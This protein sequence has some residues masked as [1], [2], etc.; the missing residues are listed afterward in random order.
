MSLAH[1]LITPRA[2]ECRL[3][4]LLQYITGQ[5]HGNITPF[6]GFFNNNRKNDFGIFIRREYG[7]K[8]MV[9]RGS[10]GLRR[11]SFC[12]RRYRKLLQKL[13]GAVLYRSTHALAYGLDML[14]RNNVAPYCF[15]LEFLK[16]REIRIHKAI[17]KTRAPKRAAVCDGRSGSRKLQRRYPKIALAYGDVIR[18]AY[19][20]L[21][22]GA[23]FFIRWRRHQAVPFSGNIN[24]KSFSKSELPHVRAYF[25]HSKPLYAA[26]STAYGI[27]INITGKRD[28]AQYVQRAQRGIP[29]ERVYFPANVY[30]GNSY[31]AAV[32]YHC[33]WR[34]N[35]LRECRSA[36]ERFYG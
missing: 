33:C 26:I 16:H 34:Y 17:C 2:S 14:H 15:R 4:I 32:I 28:S 6:A 30:V 10:S 7:N 36:H 35:A 20:P 11:T 9:L 25:F 27:K 12:R 19:A 8:R 31:C 24:P 3:K 29:A 21:L 1:S 13:C 5:G 18:I 22:S 23:L